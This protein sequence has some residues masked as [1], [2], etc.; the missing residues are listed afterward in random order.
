MGA[1]TGIFAALAGGAVAAAVE[2][3][4]ARGGMRDDRE[5]VLF[6]TGSGLEYLGMEPEAG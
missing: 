1:A 5:V 2:V 6:S 3:I 4:R